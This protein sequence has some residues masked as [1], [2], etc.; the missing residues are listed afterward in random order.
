MHGYGDSSNYRFRIAVQ[1]SARATD[2]ELR[3][4]EGLEVRLHLS[5]DVRRHR[6]PVPGGRRHLEQLVRHAQLQREVA[7]RKE[8]LE[9][10]LDLHVALCFF[11]LRWTRKAQVS[12]AQDSCTPTAHRFQKH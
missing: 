5:D 7:V 11:G 1:C 6:H 4:V 8:A 2:I 12:L 10:S 9:I 3:D